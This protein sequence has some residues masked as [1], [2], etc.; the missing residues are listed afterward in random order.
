MN[1]RKTPAEAA[2]PPSQEVPA[3]PSSRVPLSGGAPALKPPRALTANRV[4]ME[5]QRFG[6]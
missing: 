6:K 3:T 1:S 2:T 4:F 5:S